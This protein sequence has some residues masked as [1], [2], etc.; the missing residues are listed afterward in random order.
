MVVN[1]DIAH[2]ARVLKS[3][4]TLARAGAE[5]VVL[6]AATDGLSAQA[7]SGG[8]TFRRVPVLPPRA[9]NGAYALWAA[10]RRAGRLSAPEHW[11]RAL[12]ATGYF[13]R[14]W[15]PALAALAPDVVHVHDVHPLAAAIEYAETARRPVR[16]IYD[17]HEYVPGLAV[18]GARTQR[19][20]DGWAAM[21]REFVRRADRVITVA[22]GIAEVLQGTYALPELP[23]VV[24]N[25][26]VTGDFTAPRSLRA[27][28]RVADDVPLAV[29]SGALSAA[30]GVDTA[31]AALAHAPGVHLAVVSVPYPH[32]FAAQ[33]TAT[34]ARAGVADRL[35]LVPPVPSVTVPSY[36]CSADVAVSPILPVSASYDMAL[37]NKLFE[38]LHA[39]LPI[40]VSD[41]KAMAAFVTEHGLG[42]SFHAGDAADLA[43]ALRATLE[44]PPLPDTAVL[45]REFSWQA[46]ESRL[47]AAYDGLAEGLVVPSDPFPVDEIALDWQRG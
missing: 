17:A 11:R 10:R 20:V 30:R 32:P 24:Y 25:A 19:A 6:G 16:V 13:R 47:V 31:V 29:Y 14:A 42:R 45:R 28:A 26:P 12:P 23:H 18:G 8:V 7:V 37:P 22:P 40:V 36:L 4:T 43:N 2:D 38:F 46:Q 44:D 15:V 21:E 34:A 9:V 33:L 41:C 5:V 27:E 3:A 1:N 35:H 39:G